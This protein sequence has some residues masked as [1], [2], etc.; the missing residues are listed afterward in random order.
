MTRDE[1]ARRIG[2]HDD[3]AVRGRGAFWGSAII[4][5]DLYGKLQLPENFGKRAPWRAVSCG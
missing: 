1:A 5:T 3:L 4:G 2:Q